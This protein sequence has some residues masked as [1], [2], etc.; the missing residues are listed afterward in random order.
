MISLAITLTFLADTREV[1]LFVASVDTPAVPGTILVTRFGRWAQVVADSVVAR[2][3]L[4]LGTPLEGPALEILDARPTKRG[5]VVLRNRGIDLYD[6]NMRRTWTSA[7]N[8][9]FSFL[10]FAVLDSDD[11]LI[12]LSGTQDQLIIFRLSD[13]AEVRV[14]QL[15]E[16]VDDIAVAAKCALGATARGVIRVSLGLEAGVERNLE[17]EAPPRFSERND[18]SGVAVL[19]GNDVF[20][21]SCDKQPQ[22]LELFERLDLGRTRLFGSP[23]QLY[24]ITRFSWAEGGGRGVVGRLGDGGWSLR[25][26]GLLGYTSL[27]TCG[28]R[29]RVIGTAPTRWDR[30]SEWFGGRE[31][32]VVLVGID[33]LGTEFGRLRISSDMNF[34]PTRDACIGLGQEA[35]LIRRTTRGLVRAWSMTTRGQ[36]TPEP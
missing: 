10:G 22:R 24:F 35:V 17:C 11:R 20:R 30:I 26:K 16:L 31:V 2:G 19:C 13:G 25:L 29:L 14:I 18:S 34:V 3:I 8:R 32:A 27:T 15:G 6:W 7:P 4:Q 23:E 33:E 9:A 5:V 21:A 28:D 36:L 12:A 1:D